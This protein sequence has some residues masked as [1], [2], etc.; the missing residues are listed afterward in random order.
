M[1]TMG[2]DD[3]VIDI[4]GA[5]T[6]AENAEK[7]LRERSTPITTGQQEPRGEKTTKRECAFDGLVIKDESTVYY[8]TRGQEDGW[9]SRLEVKY[10]NK[11]VLVKGWTT[12]RIYEPGEW[13][14]QI[15]HLLKK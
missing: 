7:L 8:D 4:P 2:L 12:I 1:I 9:S 13:E 3:K 14:Q 15:S 11:V 5:K 6:A 10:G